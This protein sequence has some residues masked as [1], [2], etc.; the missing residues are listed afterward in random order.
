M[1]HISYF[2]TKTNKN[3]T[4]Q[5]ENHFLLLILIY[6]N[7]FRNY[8]SPQYMYPKLSFFNG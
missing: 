3:K 7:L 6:F 4:Y 8:F 2:E 5:Y 1:V